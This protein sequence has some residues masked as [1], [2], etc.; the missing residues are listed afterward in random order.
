MKWIDSLALADVVMILN[1]SSFLN[2]G[3]SYTDKMTFLY[4]NRAQKKSFKI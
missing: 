4:W 3:I 2:N 1:G